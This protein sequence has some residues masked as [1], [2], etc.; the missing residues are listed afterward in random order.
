VTRDCREA[1]MALLAGP[2]VGTCA[3][4][5]LARS[6][7]HLPSHCATTGLSLI[8]QRRQSARLGRSST[9]WTSSMHTPT[10]LRSTSRGR[11]ARAL[12][13][14]HRGNGERR[15]LGSDARH[16][17]VRSSEGRTGRPQ[18]HHTDP[19]GG[20][21]HPDGHP[22]P[23]VRRHIRDALDRISSSEPRSARPRGRDRGEPRRGPIMRLPGLS[24]G[25]DRPRPHR[26]YR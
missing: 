13:K 2:T 22:S 4:G 1:P 21:E 14:G 24:S 10:P 23:R 17:P 7:R 9:A 16:E 5:G 3:S 19:I 18:P 20:P 15:P 25:R 26:V 8:D 11:T 6:I 12:G